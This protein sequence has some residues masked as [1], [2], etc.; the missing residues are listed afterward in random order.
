MAGGA[1]STAFSVRVG[2]AGVAC[3]AALSVVLLRTVWK[4]CPHLRIHDIEASTEREMLMAA[5][6][7]L[8]VVLLLA[9]VSGT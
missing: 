5:G 2:W 7:L 1:L 3:T 6:I 4:W 9:V 8:A